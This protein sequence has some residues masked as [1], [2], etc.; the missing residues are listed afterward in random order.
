[1]KK[2]Y[3]TRIMSYIDPILLA[4]EL[5]SFG[6]ILKLRKLR[7]GIKRGCSLAMSM[8]K[9]NSGYGIVGFYFW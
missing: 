3:Y 6:M 8:F 9:D 1:M 7:I 4:R 2:S 5:Y